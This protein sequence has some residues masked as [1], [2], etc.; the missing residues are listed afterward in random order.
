MCKFLLFRNQDFEPDIIRVRK[1]SDVPEK[2]RQ[3]VIV[4]NVCIMINK[5]L[6]YSLGGAIYF[7]EK[8][9][10]PVYNI[11][12]AFLE[13]PNGF[14]YYEK[15]LPV[16]CRDGKLFFRHKDGKRFTNVPIE[17]QDLSDDY[18]FFNHISGKVEN[19]KKFYLHSLHSSKC[20][21]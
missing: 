18:L 4:N 13:T 2:F 11:H 19:F 9:I 7:S 20:I 5:K 14:I 16:I 21:A 8:K 10:M 15:T 12:E 6:G 1:E 17:I 3:N